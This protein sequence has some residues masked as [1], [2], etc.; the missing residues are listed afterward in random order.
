[1]STALATPPVSSAA[2]DSAVASS[3]RR[4][5]AASKPSILLAAFSLA[6]RE[7]VRFFRQ[8]TRVIGALV[9]P[10]LFWVVLGAGMDSTFQ[11]PEDWDAAAAGMSYQAYFLP[12][13]AA[14]IVLFTAIF[15]TI[16]VIEDRREGFLQGVLVAPVPRLGIVLGKVLGGAAIA[17]LQAGL[18]VALAPLLQY[19]ELAP[20]VEFL[21]AQGGTTVASVLLTVG[22]IAL[23]SV[24][25]TALGYCMA[26]PLDSTQGF[27]ALMSVVLLPMWLLSGAAFPAD[28][29]WLKWLVAAN[30]L[31]YG[32]SGLRRAMTPA[33]EAVPGLVDAAG[34][35]PVGGG[36]RDVHA[37]LPRGGGAADPPSPPPRGAVTQ[38]TD[39]PPQMPSLPR[40]I[41]YG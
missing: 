21:F 20:G 23:L 19:V 8:R 24:G 39:S 22:W 11:A 4:L 18:F 13:V 35:G 15:A 36:V 17:F 5:H 12:G 10:A 2:A 3:S 9:Q 16:S 34:R 29:G 37:R 30:P 27:H 41:R 31:T 33:L 1:M 7:L 6:Q 25:L 38:R 28:G 26:W 14:M 32:V 40:I